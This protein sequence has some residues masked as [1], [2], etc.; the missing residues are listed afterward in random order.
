[1]SIRYYAIPQG[2]FHLTFTYDNHDNHTNETHL[3]RVV[4]MRFIQMH[5]R[6]GHNIKIKSR[7]W[8]HAKLVEA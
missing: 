1:M 4:Y 5:Q 2:R 8:Y 7:K 3:I 6:Q